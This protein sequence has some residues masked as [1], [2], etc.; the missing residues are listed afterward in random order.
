MSATS[1]QSKADA[2]VAALESGDKAAAL[3]LFEQLQ[4]L[5]IAQPDVTASTGDGMRWDRQAVDKA[6]DRLQRTS[7]TGARTIQTGK[8]VF[9]NTTGGCS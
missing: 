9:K 1:I 5:M 6:V 3:A 4:I 7:R 8:M 2:A